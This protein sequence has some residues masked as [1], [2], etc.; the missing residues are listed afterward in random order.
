M[1]RFFYRL[2]AVFIV[3]CAICGNASAQKIKETMSVYDLKVGMKGYGKTVV[4][5][6]KIDNF[7]IEI[8]GILQTTK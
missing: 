2:F 5:G 3:F 4:S 7:D 8:L 1:H 6:R